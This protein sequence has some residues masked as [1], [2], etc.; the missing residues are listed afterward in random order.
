LSFAALFS[1]KMTS[2]FNSSNMAIH[3]LTYIF[4]VKYLFQPNYT[5]FAYFE[6]KFTQN[7]QLRSSRSN[8]C[9]GHRKCNVITMW[10][11]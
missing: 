8:V 3:S 5:D 10:K 6:L 2:N 7:L 9:S 11:R 4:S 1:V